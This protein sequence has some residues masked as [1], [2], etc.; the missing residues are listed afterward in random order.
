MRN[1]HSDTVRMAKVCANFVSLHMII[2]LESSLRFACQIG[3]PG[4]CVI[5]NGHLDT[6]RMAKVCTHFACLHMMI[7]FEANLQFVC[8]IVW[9]EGV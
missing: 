1:G 3:L 9:H 5:R 2:Q 6:V 4:R 7:Q 8:C